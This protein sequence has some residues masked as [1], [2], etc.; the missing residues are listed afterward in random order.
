VTVDDWRLHERRDQTGSKNPSTVWN[1]PISKGRRA[2]G[3]RIGSESRETEK[4]SLER[5]REGR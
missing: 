1:G 3:Q 5:G 4:F 2:V